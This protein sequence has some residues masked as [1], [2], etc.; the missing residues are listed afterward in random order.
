MFDDIRFE[1]DDD[2]T[3]YWICPAKKYNVGLFGGVT[4]GRVVYA[5]LLRDRC[6]IMT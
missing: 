6:R 3:P 2:G 5:M 4:V 1:I